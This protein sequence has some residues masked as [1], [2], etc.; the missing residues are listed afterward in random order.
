MV[1]QTIAQYRI[2]EKLGGGG[3]GVVYRAEDTRLGRSVALKFLPEELSRDPQAIE[4]FQ[5]EARAASAL[6]HP[7]I[8]T[9]HDI[10]EHEGQHFMVMELLEGQ[11]L[12]YGIGGRPMEIGLLLD[13]GI[14][15]AD[16]L[17]AAHSQGIIHRDIK[18]PNLFVTKR[19]HAKILDFGLAKLAPQR[20]RVAEAV[21][22][23]G[24]PTTVAGENL[25]SPGS[26]VGTI[27]YMSP[28]QARG[29]ELD[30]RSDIFSFGAVLYEMATG[31]QAF[32]GDTAALIHDALLNRMPPSMVRLNPDLPDALER[33]I[34][35]ALEKDRRMRY[36][37]AADMRTDLARLRRDTDSA[38]SAPAT[39]TPASVVD[40]RSSDTEIAVTLVRRH[41][42][43]LLVALT[44]VALLAA[45][46][47]YGLYRFASPTGV[48]DSVAV[49]P[50]ENLGGDPDAEYLSDGIA[51]NI[52]SSLSQLAGLKV[53][54]SG[55]VSRYKG[56]EPDPQA[57]GQELGV[58]A[59][60]TG[61]IVQR[62]SN[63]LISTE[64]VDVEDNSQI[65]G[66]QYS[67]SLAEIFSVQEE[68]SRAIADKLRIRLTG[69]EEARL[70]KRNTKNTEAYQAYLRG[71]YHWNKRTGEDLK[72][73][74]GYFEQAIRKDQDYALAYVGLADC[75]N[76]LDFYT[77][78]PPTQ[79]FPQAKAAALKALEYDDT[80]AEAHTSL[81]AV[82]HFYEWDWLGAEEEY[83]RAIELNPG[84]PTA[85]HWYA[86][87]L[88][89]LGQH[90]KAIAEIKHALELDPLSLI[91]NSDAGSYIY[92]ARQHDQAIEQLHKTIEIDPNFAGAHKW[93]GE[94]YVQKG[95]YGAAIEEFQKAATLSP[96]NPRYEAASVYAYAMVGKR[97]DA[98]N[99]LAALK[100]GGHLSAI[101]VA[102]I[103]TGLDEKEQALEWLEKAYEKHESE[104][105]FLKVDPRFDPLR[106]DPRFQ[107]LLRRMNFPP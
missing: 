89:M 62:G 42:K 30:V 51:E 31:R 100:K 17:D 52:R 4:R 25:T 69:A 21:G 39:R 80:L 93:L 103:H 27:A 29:E 38:R 9:I 73:A 19:G 70:A 20:Q 77:S 56:Q 46:V 12:K 65:W 24:D 63:L 92:Y 32:G 22:A 36:Q 81:A 37:S 47:G 76:V 94:T 66:E 104:L 8:C 49:L 96:G 44:A 90:E 85:H 59:V 55:S 106:S 105:A 41:K 98:T 88:T 3:M 1:G 2:K 10:G 11:T 58:R 53:M 14:Q 91:I 33:I 57:V 72:K 34:N 23:L 35:K 78:L 60:L 7:N 67:R 75:Y 79:T 45:G 64:L 18:P 86:E 95:M 50:F 83:R 74:I 68:I 28:E 54:S 71:R 43:G 5:R 6:N 16:A 102:V 101:G 82:K 61:R 48:I 97:V 87:L 26:T 40:D 84:Y 13:L 15:I 107:S 99:I